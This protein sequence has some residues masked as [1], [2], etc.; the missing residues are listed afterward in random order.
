MGRWKT[1][2]YLMG[3]RAFAYSDTWKYGHSADSM[4]ETM[5]RLQ[6]GVGPRH[7]SPLLLRD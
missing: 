2:V 4:L 5:E 6:H 1:H 3:V 7:K